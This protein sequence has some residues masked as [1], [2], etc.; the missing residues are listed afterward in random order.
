[1]PPN[2]QITLSRDCNSVE[3][4]SG[5]RNL[6]PAGTIVRVMQ[7]RG[8]S[9][10]VASNTGAMYRID[11]QDADALGLSATAPAGAA[12]EGEKTAAG[13]LSEKMVLDQLRSVYD[14][15][16]PVNIVDL[17]RVYSCVISAQPEGRRRIDVKMAMTAPGCGMADV[18]KADVEARLKGLPEVGEVQ[19]EIVFDPPWHAGRMSEAARQQ[20]GLDPVDDSSPSNF[21]I[22]RS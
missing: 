4:P 22:F 18:L 6:L 9:Y 17:G 19:V 20:L 1:M 15:E 5:A 2:Q 3:I 16:I 14:P 8:G 21:P 7:S 13:P 12:A 11:G 10:T